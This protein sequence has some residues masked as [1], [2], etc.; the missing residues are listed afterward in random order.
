MRH[1]LG[2]GSMAARLRFLAFFGIACLLALAVWQAIDIYRSEYAARQQ[3]TRQAVEVAHGVLVWAHGQETSGRLDRPAAQALAREALAKLRYSGSEYFWVN[4]FQARVVMHPI[5]PELDGQ[6]GSQ[7]RDANGVALFVA[8]AETGRRD[9]AGFVSY[10]WPKP[11]R[12]D[13]VEKLS[14]VK[15]FAPWGWVVGSGI[16][17]D[18]LRA[19]MWRHVGQLGLVVLAA[20]VVAALISHRVSRSILGGLSSAIEVS[21]SIAQ[22]D[23]GREVR[24]PPGQGEVTQLMQAQADMTQQLRR[25]VTLVQSSAQGVQVAASEIAAGTA[26]LSGRTEQ[27]ASSLQET[28][29]TMAQI[30]GTVVQNAHAARQAGEISAAAA[31]TAVDG[32]R[33]VG[34]VVNTMAQITTSS[35][36]IADITGVIDGI[37]FQTNILALNA[38]VEAARAGEHGRGFA[39]VATEVR[40]LATRSAEAAREIKALIGESAERVRTGGELVDRAGQT[41][42]QIVASV[43]ELHTLLATME[44]A[45]QEQATGVGQVNQAV[46]SL[47]EATQRNSALVEQSAASAAAMR[48]QSRQLLAAVQ[49]FRMEALTA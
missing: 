28:A 45:N 20:L 19:S 13:A 14:Y 32:S 5:K 1:V 41:I 34:E 43:Q 37:A 8:F 42:E 47:D 24:V 4:D 7:I 17:L 38:A 25:M 16:Y 33:L 3:A 48:E 29:A 40:Q 15:A 30:H 44:R 23:I 22:G 10:L 36:R 35:T 11:G 46:A 27:T 2:V 6:D 39:V 21:R 49:A 18:D 9:G 31:S 26:D 12:E